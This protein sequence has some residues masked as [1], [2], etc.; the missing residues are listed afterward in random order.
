MGERGSIG[1]PARNALVLFPIVR[2]L[3]RLLLV[4]LA[5][6]CAA[7]AVSVADVDLAGT[8]TV[9]GAQ[10]AAEPVRL[11]RSAVV[12]LNGIR[13][14]GGGDLSAVIL[15]AEGSESERPGFIAGQQRGPIGPLP[16][17]AP[18][19]RD[20]VQVGPAEWRVP[21][22]DYRLYFV[23]EGLPASVTVEFAGLDGAVSFAPTRTVRATVRHPGQRGAPQGVVTGGDTASLDGPGAL[24]SLLTTRY[25]AVVADET[26]HCVYQGEESASSPTA[27]TPGCPTAQLRIATNFVNMVPGPVGLQTSL[28]AVS[29]ANGVF[30]QGYSANTVGVQDGLKYSALWLTFDQSPRSDG[31]V[32]PPGPIGTSLPAAAGGSQPSAGGSS[33][34]SSPQPPSTGPGAPATSGRQLA[35]RRLTVGAASR[36]SVLRQGLR[37]T[38]TGVKG[39]VRLRA[40]VAGR[41]IATGT[42]VARGDRA[43]V[44][45]RP[46]RAGRRFLQRGRKVVEVSVVGAGLVARARLR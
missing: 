28:V 23:G 37:A 14:Q 12:A 25:R 8:T 34:A 10:A 42:A 17:F 16:F 15:I 29:A 7:P 27:H 45:L 26:F 41:T 39:R 21:A 13:V 4:L 2:S 43:Q 30:G 38:L 18:M 44:V 33:P 32:I 24:F 1:D 35:L 22:G 9:N 11:S 5:G 40:V 19:G 20:I 3:T 46:T 6:L 31:R 36:R